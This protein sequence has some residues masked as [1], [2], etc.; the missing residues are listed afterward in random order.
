MLSELV[1]VGYGVVKKSDLTGAV[2]KGGKGQP[3]TG[4]AVSTAGADIVDIG[5]S[6]RR[7]LHLRR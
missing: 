5:M 6:Q 7:D 3:L 2:S 4:T 1:V